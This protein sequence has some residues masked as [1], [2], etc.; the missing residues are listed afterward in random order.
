MPAGGDPDI[1]RFVQILQAEV[2]GDN[3]GQGDGWRYFEALFTA[4]G[5]TLSQHTKAL[6]AK[7]PRINA[8]AAAFLTHTDRLVNPVQ[9][10]AVTTAAGNATA[11]D[12]VDRLANEALRDLQVQQSQSVA[13][14]SGFN[15]VVALGTA[16]QTDQLDHIRQ[17]TAA[18]NAATAAVERYSSSVAQTPMLP[19]PTYDPPLGADPTWMTGPGGGAAAAGRPGGAA[20][21]PVGGAGATKPLDGTG[22][23]PLDV[24]GIDQVDAEPLLGAGAAPATAPPAGGAGPVG[25]APPVGGAHPGGPPL[26]GIGP[27]G[28]GR[29]GG[30]GSLGGARTP[31]RGIGGLGSVGGARTPVRGI[32]GLGSVGG[33]VRPGVPPPGGTGGTGDL[34]AV[35]GEAGPGGAARPTGAVPPVIGGRGAAGRTPL[36]GIG[37][38]GGA[39]GSGAGGVGSL[40]GAG[41]RGV[42]GGVGPV[43]GVAPAGGARRVAGGGSGNRA[44]GGRPIAGAGPGGVTGAPHG[45]PAGGVGGARGAGGAFVGPPF[46]GSARHGDGDDNA[47]DQ[48]GAGDDTALWTVPRGAPSVVDAGDGYRD[49]DPGPAIG[50]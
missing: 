16:T 9:A 10:A 8:A 18:G 36:G 31:V 42:G 24:G 45:S 3:A 11:M 38:L 33:G 35:G 40:G 46:G 43:G 4:L 2:D 12:S 15:K 50:R 41:G 21:A 44:G 19:P 23:A 26:G 17:S 7:W 30:L 32:G 48:T 28:G 27:V 47:A 20:S 39:G 1:A 14:D 25:G 22:T 13:I 29:I 6:E 34:G 5:A 49:T 37:P